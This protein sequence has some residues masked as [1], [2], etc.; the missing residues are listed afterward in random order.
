MNSF[1]RLIK[2]PTMERARY[3]RPKIYESSMDPYVEH[4][5]AGCHCVTA[6]WL[7]RINSNMSYIVGALGG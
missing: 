3:I 1:S 7:L 5:I 2:R 4:R 6:L